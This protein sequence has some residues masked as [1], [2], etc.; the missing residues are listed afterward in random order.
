MSGKMNEYEHR[1]IK[2]LNKL[3][4]LYRIEMQLDRLNGLIEELIYN[5]NKKDP[6]E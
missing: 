2:E 4:N 6:E 3:K 1:V 5:N